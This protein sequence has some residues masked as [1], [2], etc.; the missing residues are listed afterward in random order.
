[1][2]YMISKHN[3]IN[4]QTVTIP[5]IIIANIAQRAGLVGCESPWYSPSP[6]PNASF[7]DFNDC[8]NSVLVFF[9]SLVISQWPCFWAS[10]LWQGHGNG[11]WRR[12]VGKTL[13]PGTSDNSISST[14]IYHVC[15]SKHRHPWLCAM[16]SNLVNRGINVT[17]GNMA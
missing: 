1:M 5:N 14:H 8:P 4:V 16:R 7:N 17:G 11:G 10:L 2:M 6:T 3:T 12:N 13:R 9:A 15:E